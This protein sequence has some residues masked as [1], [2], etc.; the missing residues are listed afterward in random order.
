M[1]REGGCGGCFYIWLVRSVRPSWDICIYIYI[2]IFFFFFFFS[3]G[4]GVSV[5]FSKLTNHRFRLVVILLG[6]ALS[7]FVTGY[8]RLVNHPFEVDIHAKSL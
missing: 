8:T 4:F 3:P 2:Y 1:G 6:V 7:V 5:S